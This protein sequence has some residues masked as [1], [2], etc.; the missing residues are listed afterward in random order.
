MIVAAVLIALLL[1]LLTTCQS[2]GLPEVGDKIPQGRPSAALPAASIDPDQSVYIALTLHFDRNAVTVV[3]QPKVRA[4]F[5]PGAGLETS[6]R[7]RLYDQNGVVLYET[8]LADPLIIHVFPDPSELPNA[9]GSRHDGHE[10]EVVEQ[11]TLP[12]SLPLLATAAYLVVARD[13]RVVLVRDLRGDLAAAC[14][15]NPHSLCREWITVHR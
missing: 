11:S 2:G 14:E 4:G 15:D 8:G 7:I 5:A 10:T 9:S 13:A 6:L 1:A 3:E 12:L